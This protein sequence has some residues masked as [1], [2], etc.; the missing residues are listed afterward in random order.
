MAIDIGTTTVVAYF[1]Q[2]SDG[3]LRCVQSGM[4]EQRAFGA[5]V[6]SRINYS[7]ENG[8]QALQDA[9]DFSA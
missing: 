4:N 8:L 7:N 6:I 2:M 9:I 5:D 3:K 1:Y